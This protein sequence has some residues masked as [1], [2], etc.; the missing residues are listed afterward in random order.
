[1]NVERVGDAFANFQNDN[2]VIYM[3][4]RFDSQL[5]HRLRA[6]LPRGN[7]FAIVEQAELLRRLRLLKTENAV[8]IVDNDRFDSVSTL[9]RAA[10]VRKVHP[11]VPVIAILQDA[12]SSTI[13]PHCA[14][15]IICR[16]AASVFD[17][18]AALLSATGNSTTNA[19]A[20]D[21]DDLYGWPAGWWLLPMMLLGFFGWVTFAWMVFG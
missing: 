5:P 15:V 9:D 1:M 8:V 6:C 7:V 21:I 10:E 19:I 17:L 4:G 3:V 11:D 14:D 2:L 12:N 13:P 18:I 20:N 16:H